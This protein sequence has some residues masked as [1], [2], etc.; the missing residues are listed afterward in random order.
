[1][2]IW[3]LLKSQRIRPR[4]K[5]ARIKTEKSQKSKH[6]IKNQVKHEEWVSNDAIGGKVSKVVVR[7]T[8]EK[9][10]V[11]IEKVIKIS[12]AKSKTKK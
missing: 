5:I 4:K 8:E 11:A 1:M 6:N 10:R 2:Q 3:C 7:L 12:I 9:D